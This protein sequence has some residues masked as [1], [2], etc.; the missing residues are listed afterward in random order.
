MNS[1]FLEQDAEEAPV[2]N[3]ASGF[4]IYF[5]GCCVGYI[6]EPD[7]SKPP[8]KIVIDFFN[9]ILVKSD[10]NQFLKNYIDHILFQQVKL[11][12]KI[13]LQRMRKNQLQTKERFVTHRCVQRAFIMKR[14]ITILCIVI[15]SSSS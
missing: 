14:F 13:F 7:I 10:L 8:N 2:A 1:P 3:G 9:I 12:G 4:S 11:L 6:I 5:V 15:I